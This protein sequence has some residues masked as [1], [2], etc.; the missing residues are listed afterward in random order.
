MK[1]IKDIKEIQKLTENLKKEGKSIGFVPTMGYLHEGHLSL[2]R[3]SIKENSTT[4]V[5]IFVNP[6]Q[7]GPAE[8]F[9]SYPRD[10][11]R[12]RKL[13]EN[14]GVDYLFYPT[15]KTMYPSGYSTFVNVT[16]LDETLCGRRREGHFR[17]VVTVVLK[18][19]NIVQPHS[20]Y[21]GQKDAQQA[22]IIRQMIKDLNL[23][24]RFRVLPI[25]RE[26]DGLAMSSRNRYLTA[27]EREQAIALYKSLKKAE[28]LFER[29]ERSSLKIKQEILKILYSHDLLKIDYVEIVDLAKLRPLNI[30][31]DKALVAVAVYLG[32]ARLIDNT[33]LGGNNEDLCS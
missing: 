32:K 9:S 28:E 14:E 1:I 23:N 21:F 31:K 26:K 6:T 18:L 12:D 24:I 8:D 2:V 25:V 5:S 4:F 13:L 19:F 30:I 29:G 15:S 11:E 17:G 7:F 16:F 3:E 20:T 10:L 27:D 22:L 33:I